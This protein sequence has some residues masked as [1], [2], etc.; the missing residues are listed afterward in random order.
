MHGPSL[1]VISLACIFDA[2]QDGQRKPAKAPNT[3]TYFMQ[4][5]GLRIGTRGS[6]LALAQ[7]NLTAGLLAALDIA[8]DKAA[9]EIVP[10]RT[11]GDAITDRPL[12]EAGGKG[13]FTKEIDDALLAG[14][15]DIAVHSAKDLPTRLPDGIVIAACLEREDVRDAILSPTAS[16]LTDLPK[17]AVLGTSSLRRKAL[18]LRLRP[19]LAVVDFRGN[20]ETRLGK[21]AAG[22]A[23]A[24]LLAIAGLK[25]LGLADRARGILDSDEWLP[26]VG[27]GAIAITARRDDTAIL[28]VLAGL[29]HHDT[30]VALAAERAFLAV[31][32]G[33][34]RTPIGGLARLEADRLVFRGI[35]VKPDGSEAHAVERRGPVADAEILGADAGAELARRGGAGFFAP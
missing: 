32:D 34:C 15:I 6:P 8:G 12:S 9:A 3:G 18:A 29:D 33:S 30:S 16:R 26:A 24:T 7:A 1:P 14:R 10:I 20:V 11:S 17:G 25:R 28:S 2:A 22:A 35:I 23:D 19:D 4:S 27:Q 21:L 31:L 13:L 5:A